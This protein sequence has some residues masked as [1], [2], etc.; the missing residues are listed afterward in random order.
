MRGGRHGQT[1]GRLQMVKVTALSDTETLSSSFAFNS[2]CHVLK[3]ASEKRAD[4]RVDSRERPSCCPKGLGE[5]LHGHLALLSRILAA[6][7][8][9]ATLPVCFTE[10]ADG[11]VTQTLP[12]SV[13]SEALCGRMPDSA[14]QGIHYVQ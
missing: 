12:A 2:L 13:V 1:L 10:S 8:H 9:N 4:D 11:H 14:S 7:A 5:G 6:P 3:S